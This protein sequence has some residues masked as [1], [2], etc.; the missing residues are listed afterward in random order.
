MND[1]ARR[2]DA[3]IVAMT[4]VDL[5]EALVEGPCDGDVSADETGML[6]DM[7]ARLTAGERYGLSTKQRAFAEDILRRV[8][9]LRAADAPRGREVETPAVLRNLPKSPPGRAAR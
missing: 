6:I 9:P 3:R 4:D 5:L 2:R 1:A 8:M 7:L